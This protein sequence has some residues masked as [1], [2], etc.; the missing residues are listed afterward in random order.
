MFES[1]ETN[2]VYRREENGL[3]VSV[4]RVWINNAMDVLFFECQGPNRFDA[5]TDDVEWGDSF[6]ARFNREDVVKFLTERAPGSM[7]MPRT[8]TPIIYSSEGSLLVEDGTVWVNDMELT[9]EEVVA[10]LN[11]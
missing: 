5:E 9:E 2:L 8:C 10:L 1:K 4:R 3:T 11:N 7:L 6:T